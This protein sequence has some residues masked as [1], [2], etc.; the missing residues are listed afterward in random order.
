MSHR[1]QQIESTLQRAIT[2]VL[3]AR[4]SDPRLE[5]ALL[6]VTR[7]EL[8]PDLREASVFVSVIP[9]QRQTLVHAALEHA[10]GR[11]AGQIRKAITMRTMPR[12]HFKIDPTL[13][14]Q[15]RVYDA[16]SESA[17]RLPA[18]GQAPPEPLPADGPS[19]QET[20]P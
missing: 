13:K 5:G 11:V 19:G 15:D 17:S 7:V 1:K 8:T 16:I 12:L 20:A 3:A 9:Q 10:A 6:S 14:N 2:Q 18:A 4:L